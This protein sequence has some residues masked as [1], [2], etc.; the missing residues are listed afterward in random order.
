[1]SV[2]Y[3][4]TDRLLRDAKKLR[5]HISHKLGA[6]T[7]P[8]NAMDLIANCFGWSSWNVMYVAIQKRSD[9]HRWWHDMR[10]REKV[11]HMHRYI[12]SVSENVVTRYSWAKDF[13]NRDTLSLRM[14]LTELLEPNQNTLS[15]KEKPSGLIGRFLKPLE[16]PN[17]C[18]LQFSRSRQREGVFISSND[19]Y[20]VSEHLHNHMLPSFNDPDAIVVCE[21]FSQMDFVRTFQSRGYKL[22]ALNTLG[23]DRRLPYTIDIEDRTL[24]PDPTAEV[25][26]PF[27]IE[28]YLNH[29]LDIRTFDEEEAHDIAFEASSR[30]AVRIIGQL[31][32]QSKVTPF[33]FDMFHIPPLKSVVRWSEN[34]NDPVLKMLCSKFL[35]LFVGDPLNHSHLKDIIDSNKSAALEER[36][37]Y[38]FM[39]IGS[40][41]ESLREK[42]IALMDRHQD[43]FVSS[44]ERDDGKVVYLFPIDRSP[45]DL[46]HLRAMMN[47][48]QVRLATLPPTIK[49]DM[50]LI[51][52]EN[53]ELSSSSF[54]KNR[55]LN[56]D[57]LNAARLN[58]LFFGEQGAFQDTL[59]THVHLKGKSFSVEDRRIDLLSELSSYGATQKFQSVDFTV[60]P[61]ER[62]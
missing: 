42:F 53:L 28:S 41:L 35:K 26:S 45:G 4:N 61:T 5:K 59:D 44:F 48:L 1:M 25:E 49:P 24:L 6:D 34:H 38:S 14:A 17:P 8:Q 55:T 31:A 37:Q 15:T 30:M 3:K 58:P 16:S 20:F 46:Q 47:M 10:W 50:W 21:S 23:I 19:S 51:S 52:Q 7:S 32:R 54:T 57:M 9:N 62:D 29:S 11:A 12:Y 36:Y 39:L 2:L 18:Y 13:S 43:H 60:E 33:S 27:S 22:V 56:F 40:V